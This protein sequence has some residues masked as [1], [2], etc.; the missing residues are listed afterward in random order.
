M[1]VLPNGFTWRRHDGGRIN[2]EMIGYSKLSSVLNDCRTDGDTTDSA[3]LPPARRQPSD[4]KK[5]QTQWP[6]A[7][8]ISR[9]RGTRSPRW[10]NV[11][12][13]AG[14][15]GTVKNSERLTCV[16]ENVNHGLKRRICQV[17]VRCRASGADAG[18]TPNQHLAWD[19]LLSPGL[20]PFTCLLF[21][22]CQTLHSACDKT[23][24][25]R[26]PLRQI[27]YANCCACFCKL[28]VV[29]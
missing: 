18:P 3:L 20:K 11:R 23:L 7:G 9:Q 4:P 26:S 12:R 15:R 28:G 8:S 1:S 16:R 10:A 14:T 21:E 24:H 2:W 25:Y 29:A 5:L 17:L 22:Q 27:H 19:A 13:R 6:N